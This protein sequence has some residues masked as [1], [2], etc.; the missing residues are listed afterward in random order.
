MLGRERFYSSRTELRSCDTF[1]DFFF[2]SF[3][4]LALLTLISPFAISRALSSFDVLAETLKEYSVLRCPDAHAI[5]DLAMY[6]YSEVIGSF[7]GQ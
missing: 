6:N 3:I 1:R 5:N 4:Q 2:L 7:M